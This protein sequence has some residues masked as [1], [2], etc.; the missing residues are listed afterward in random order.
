MKRFKVY[1]QHDSMECGMTCLRMICKHYGAEYSSEYLSRLCF[2]TNEGVSLL[3]MSEAAELL[4]LHT[5]CG[6]LGLEQLR[7]M[8][9]PCIL[10]WNQNHFVVLYRIS[11]NGKKFYIADP[12]KGLLTRSI[13]DMEEHW[14]ST[15]SEGGDK[16]VVMLIE[17]T[18][19]FYD[20]MKNSGDCGESRSFSFL[21]GY[22]KKYR[23]YFGQIAV[24]LAL[25]CLL[26]LVLPFLT[27]AIVDVGIKN[28]DIGFCMARAAGAADAD[29]KPN[30]SRLHTPLAAAAHQHEGEH[31]VDKRLLHNS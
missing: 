20:R 29:G 15:R 23:K 11:K 4:G 26:Q 24:G 14:V 16:G 5:I 13:K 17:T 8:P 1:L 21:F 7:N 6:R 28:R 27:Q 25:G 2:A 22:L 30:G 3:G 9:L 31:I 12:G 19:M 18:P 10:H